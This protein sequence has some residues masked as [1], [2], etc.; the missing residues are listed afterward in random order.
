MNDIEDVVDVI[1]AIQDG[2]IEVVIQAIQLNHVTASAR[3][4]EGSIIISKETLQQLLLSSSKKAC[5]HYC[6]ISLPRRL[7]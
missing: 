3:D 4:Q 6:H 5:N 1:S 7:G 2:D